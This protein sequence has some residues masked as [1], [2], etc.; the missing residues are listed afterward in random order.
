MCDQTSPIRVRREVAYT[1][2]QHF[3]APPLRG[4]VMDIPLLF[5]IT[6]TLEDSDIRCEA[7]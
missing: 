5:R 2:S 3:G 1:A 6:Q 7:H 4:A